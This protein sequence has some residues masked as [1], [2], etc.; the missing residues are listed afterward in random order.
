MQCK[1]SANSGACEVAVL[2]LATARSGGLFFFVRTAAS[3]KARHSGDRLLLAELGSR[4]PTTK[5]SPTGKRTVRPALNGP[6]PTYGA[7]RK[8]SF[9]ALSPSSRVPRRQV[10]RSAGLPTRRFGEIP[11]RRLTVGNWVS[12]AL[13]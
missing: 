11:A 1:Q 2:G 12:Y 13:R 10:D 9:E 8:Q 3:G 4:H 7:L 5:R 6:L